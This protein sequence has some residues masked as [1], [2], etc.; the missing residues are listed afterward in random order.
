MLWMMKT[1]SEIEHIVNEALTK[2]QK[3]GGSYK[4]FD[5]IMIGEN[6]TFKEVKSANNNF[7]GAFT[8]GVNNKNYIFINAGIDNIGRKHFTIAHEL[9]HY[10][11]S[12]N[13]HNNL[14]F[15]TNNDITEEGH[16]QDPIEREANYFASCFLMPEEKIRP[17][18]LIL[19]EN[20]SRKK[21]KDFLVVKND[22]TFGVWL[23]IRDELTKRYGVSEA[24][25]RYRLQQLKLARFEFS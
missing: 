14:G 18:F 10:F 22:Y 21:I 24:A 11:L 3:R 4:L 13:L 15:C 17:A 20:R 23:L 8:K 7:V 25:L 1:N 6:I 16:Q 9:G 12:H 19:L 2:Y 5:D